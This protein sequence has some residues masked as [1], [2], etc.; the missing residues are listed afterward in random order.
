M[1]VIEMDVQGGQDVVEML[2]LHVGQF[3]GQ[4]PHV[5]VVDQRDGGH[6]DAVR[7]LG[8]LFDHGVADQVAEGF[9]AVGVSAAGDQSVELFQEIGIDG[10][11]NPAE[12]AHSY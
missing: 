11:A 4:T 2:V 8:F 5:M 6:D 7:T 9:R 3:F 12:I 10:Y 1:I